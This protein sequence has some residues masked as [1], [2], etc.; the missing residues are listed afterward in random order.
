MT[1]VLLL[2]GGMGQELIS[3][4][5]ADTPLWSGQALI[6]D[7]DLVR[8]VHRDYVAAGARV[9]T[10]NSY[11]LG[12]HRLDRLG[13]GDRVVELNDLAGRLAREVADDAATNGIAVRVAGS[14]PPYRGSYQPDAVADHET[15]LAEYAHQA[16]ALAPHI[17]VFLAET[18]ST[19]E[20]GQ[21]ATRAARPFGKPVWVAWTMTGAEGVHIAS[22]EPIR[23]AVA[24]TTADAYLLNCSDPEQITHGLRALLAATDAPVGAYANGFKAIPAD[25]DVMRGDSL[26]E[27][28]ADLTPKRYVEF[29]AQWES[30]G[31][32]IIGG[33]CEVGPTHISAM[34]DHLG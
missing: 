16:A 11:A 12:S 9:I 7:P 19:I 1:D 30:M 29:L 24:A 28:R 3:R 33:C 17:D 22:G 21:A 25:W 31:V 10:T 13:L 34:A 8:S 4:G 27:A 23:D 32:A 14:L 26:P 5:M 6:D 2:D 18:M 15:L 20:E